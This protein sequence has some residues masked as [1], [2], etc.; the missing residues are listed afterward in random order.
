METPFALASVLMLSAPSVTGSPNFAAMVGADPAPA[1]TPSPR[2]V[3]E[4]E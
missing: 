1:V 2:P 3:V 4:A